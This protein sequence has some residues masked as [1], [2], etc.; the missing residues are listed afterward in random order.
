MCLE[1][2]EKQ[3]RHSTDNKASVTERDRVDAQEIAQGK[4]E[5]NNNN[6]Q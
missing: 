2:F 3:V 5:T 6:K 4:A 1:I